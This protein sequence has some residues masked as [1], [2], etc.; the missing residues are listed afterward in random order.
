MGFCWHWIIFLMPN[1]RVILPTSGLWLLPK[2]EAIQNKHSSIWTKVIFPVIIFRTCHGTSSNLGGCILLSQNRT[3][4]WR[5]CFQNTRPMP[6][7]WSPWRNRPARLAVNRKVGGS[8]PP[9]KCYCCILEIWKQSNV[10]TNR[11]AKNAGRDHV[12]PISKATVAVILVMCLMHVYERRSCL[13]TKPRI[14]REVLLLHP[15]NLKA[16]KCF[17]Q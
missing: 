10:S 15:W 12:I 13:T 9:G 4:N 2:F 17:D 16:I 3:Q 6:S 8:S 7:T 11:E 1:Q 5:P 14:Q